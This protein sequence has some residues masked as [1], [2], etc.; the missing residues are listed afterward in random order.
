MAQSEKTI[1]QAGELT[2]LNV[3]KMKTRQ[4]SRKRHADDDILSILG[5]WKLA[6]AELRLSWADYDYRSKFCTIEAAEECEFENQFDQIASAE[7]RLISYQPKTTLG[8][9]HM[10]EA[11][12]DILQERQRNPENNL[13][14]GPV[15]ELILNVIRALEQRDIKLRA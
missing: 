13:G 6:R 4:A 5:V 11:V 10:L 1:P 2:Q 12:V 15:I 7:E 14:K 3:I 9:Q 8:C